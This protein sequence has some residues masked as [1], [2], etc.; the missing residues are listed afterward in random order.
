MKSN[1]LKVAIIGLLFLSCQKEQ[2]QHHR[3]EKEQK[4]VTISDGR[5]VFQSTETVKTLFADC[6]NAGE[7]G[8]NN[9]LKSMLDAKGQACFLN[10]EFCNLSRSFSNSS[11][12]LKSNSIEVVQDGVLTPELVPDKE[13]SAIL[14]DKGEVQVG[15]A[16]YKVTPFGTFVTDENN[17]PSLNKLLLDHD[18]P[19]DITEKIPNHEF[20]QGR[21]L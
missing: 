11:T 12:K 21:Y 3:E 18:A 19:D 2:I 14:N 8:I 5:L 10:K 15:E 4:N 7:E 13:L 6:D 1:Y 9:K 16:V 20:Y 17:L